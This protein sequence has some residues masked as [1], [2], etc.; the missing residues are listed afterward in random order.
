MARDRIERLGGSIVQHG[1]L[2]DRV[3]LMKMGDEPPAKVLHRLE[4][5]ARKGGYSKIFA[6]VPVRARKVFL[7]EGYEEEAAVPGLFRGRE[8]GFFLSR[9]PGSWRAR[10]SRMSKVEE[11]LGAALKKRGAGP[12]ESTSL[13]IRQL[14]PEHAE[15]MAALYGLIFDSYPF[16]IHDPEYLKSTMAENIRY[17]GVLGKEGLAALS[18]TEMDTAG[19]N[20]EL[21]DFATSPKWR[22][23]GL[24]GALIRDM[25][26][27]MAERDMATAF[28]IARAESFGMNIAFA[29]MGYRVGGTLVNN[30]NIGGRL[31]S[32][33]VWYRSLKGKGRPAREGADR[34]AAIGASS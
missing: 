7:G 18:S 17:F 25:E 6:K 11:V 27:R 15:E 30:T 31:E 3:Y 26:G 34:A 33:N 23:K 10:E 9:F 20:V 19:A 16:P 1:P 8:D 21:T 22:G 24:A 4:V 14:G 29:R 32:M 28:T 5:L 12:K 2:N 13:R